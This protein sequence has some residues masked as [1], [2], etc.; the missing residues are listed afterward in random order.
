MSRKAHKEI[1]W[2][3]VATILIA[4]FL[5]LDRTA[6]G[7]GIGFGGSWTS[8]TPGELYHWL[9][10]TFLVLP[11]MLLVGAVVGPRL[12][13]TRFSV[14]ERRTGWMVALLG[15]LAA[16]GYI[17][18]Q[19]TVR[20]GFPFTDDQY[21]ARFGGELLASG[22]LMTEA[23]SYIEILPALYLYMRDGAVTSFDW[24]G[25]IFAWA[26]ADWTGLGT[27]LFGLAAGATLAAF[28]ALVGQREGREW[29]GAALLLFA[30]SPMALSL[31]VTSHAH[32]VSRCGVAV[33]LAVWVF[34]RRHQG[35]RAF[36]AWATA[37]AAL[38]LAW[39][40]RP[41]E[42]TALIL[43][44]LLLETWNARTVKERRAGLGLLLAVGAVGVVAFVIHSWF[45]TGTLMP[46]RLAGNNE[47]AFPGR[48]HYAPVLAILT[49]PEVLK[50]RL[51]ANLGY[52]VMM[53]GVYG[54]SVLAVPLAWL[55][56]RDRFDR[57]LAVGLGLAFGVALLHDDY[58]LHMVG[59]IHYSEAL[60]PY[61]Y[62]V[63][64]GVSHLHR[65]TEKARPGTHLGPILTVALVGWGI[66]FSA[67]HLAAIQR[68]SELHRTIY[69]AIDDPQYDDAIILVPN[70]S[71][72]WAKLPRQTDSYVFDWRK[73]HDTGPIL[74]V[75][76][77]R[78][79]RLYRDLVR[80][81]PHRP[82]YR[83][84]LQQHPPHLLLTPTPRARLD[85]HT[86]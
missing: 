8:S 21:G 22:R 59:P 72:V 76:G 64:R 33:G 28:V 68:E 10:T 40:T 67:P 42:T 39:M 15:G 12:A 50:S 62:L 73:R 49:D 3:G 65:Q 31:S 23:P 54:A 2:L 34:A 61:L 57:A 81:H 56:I 1:G 55:G 16:A 13:A 35:R 48:E 32:V 84:R 80:A 19:R 82:I 37:G 18:G 30:V 38:G 75:S 52:N 70:Y 86:R 78:S 83:L 46:A 71:T 45:V 7:T 4:A 9:G 53:L 47:L 85:P 17:A 77:N 41:I 25:A 60:I 58:G 63:I 74:A 66:C 69:A 44:L 20:G 6:V 43:P 24:F 27:A 29:G 26:V 14:P 51:G 36:A 79:W 5:N 11:A